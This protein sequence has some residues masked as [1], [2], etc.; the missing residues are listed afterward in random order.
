MGDPE[1]DEKRATESAVGSR[2]S[3]DNDGVDDSKQD[4]KRV[5]ESAIKVC[6]RALKLLCRTFLLAAHFNIF[7]VF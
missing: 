4:D 1:R 6:T 5:I 7:F 3:Q 2:P